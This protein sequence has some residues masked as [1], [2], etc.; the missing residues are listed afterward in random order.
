MIEA[1][2]SSSLI[3]RNLVANYLGHG[4]NAAISL[5]FVPLYIQYLGIEAYGLVGVYTMIAAWLTL[6]D[7]GLTPALG[8]EVA[9]FT[10]GARSE[11]SI[12]DLLRSME[13]VLALLATLVLV[14]FVLSAEW[15]AGTWLRIEALTIES[16]ADAISLMG[17]VIALRGL[18]SLYRSAMLGLQKQVLLNWVSAV[19]A[20]IRSAG[21]VGVLAWA[22]PTATAFFLWQGLL[23][24]LALIAFAC[25]THGSF[26]KTDQP[27]KFSLVELKSIWKFAGGMV[28]ITGLTILLTS[29]DK[30][31]L[32]K[33][34]SLSEFGYYSLAATVAAGLFTVISP[35]TQAWYPRFTQLV[36]A[37]K[38]EE[39]SANFHETAQLVTVCAGSLGV[40]V[41]V[42]SEPILRIW[43][44]DSGLVA[45]VAPLLCALILGNLLNGLMWVPYHAQLAFGWTSLTIKVNFV[46][47]CLVLPSII[48]VTPVYGAIGAALVWVLL[49]IGYVLISAQIM[50]RRILTSEKHQWYLKDIFMP[51]MPCVGVTLLFSL[52]FPEDSALVVQA[53]T[54][55]FIWFASLLFALLAAAK[56]RA[57]LKTLLLSY[58]RTWVSCDER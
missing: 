23:S 12:K 58:L 46:A 38:I 17:V 48:L 42:Y 30:L 34:L 35:V 52:V 24:V 21:A 4:W 36:A 9:R 15:L 45:A 55:F 26:P 31:A 3:K 56:L 18:E 41:A 1:S 6:L 33:L 50:F 5:A 14:V 40:F 25:V 39:F 8:R 29:V 47:V 7:A 13:V 2:Q 54:L 16:V 43:T 51:L 11:K 19:F 37:E 27:G 44:G 53:A 20:T 57:R 49:N 10:A 22:S 28:L 32:S